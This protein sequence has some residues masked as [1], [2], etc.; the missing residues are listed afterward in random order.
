MWDLAGNPKGRFS[1]NEAHIYTCGDNVCGIA[2]V[3]FRFLMKLDYFDVCFVVAIYVCVT[4]ARCAG[5]GI[6][7]ISEFISRC[8]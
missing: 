6:A 3:S 5:N 7:H 4:S 8:C 2:V 1:H